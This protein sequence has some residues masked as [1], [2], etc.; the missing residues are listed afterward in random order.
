MCITNQDYMDRFKDYEDDKELDM[1]M[2]EWEDEA[3]IEEALIV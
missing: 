3:G 1:D 2:R